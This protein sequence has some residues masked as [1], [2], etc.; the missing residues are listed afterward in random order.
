MTLDL[1][2]KKILV[3]DDFPEMRSMMRK[4]AVAF[5]AQEIDDARNGEDA[6]KLM[7]RNKYDIVLCDYNLGPGKDGQNVLEEAKHKSLINHSTVFMLITAENTLR[8]VMG[9]MEYV[10]DGYLTKPFTKGEFST[11][12]EKIQQKK[13]NLKEIEKAMQRNDY[14]A[15]VLACDEKLAENPPNIMELLKIKADMYEKMGDYEAAATV[16]NKV[17]DSREIAWASLGVARIHL[18]QKNYDDAKETLQRLIYEN[19]QYIEAYDLLAK[20]YEASDD[21]EE[22]QNILKKALEISPKAILRLKTLGQIA[23]KNSDLEVAESS[24]KNAVRLGKHSC[25]K[26]ASDYTGLAKV[27]LDKKSPVEALKLVGEIREMFEDNNHAAFQAAVMESMVHKQTGNS[28]LANQAITKANELFAAI[29]ENLPLDTVMDLAKTCLALG[30]AEAGAKYAK[31]IV[32]NHHEDEAV[33]KQTQALFNEF[34]MGDTGN[35]LINA[36][37]QEVIDVNNQGVRLAK[38]GKFEESIEFFEKAAGGMPE[39]KTVNLNAAQSLILFMQKSGKKERLLRQTMK[40]LERAKKIDPF[41]EK[42][43]K[44]MTFYTKLSTGK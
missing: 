9:A 8:M 36:A 1:T 20:V 28:E 17:L 4:M 13:A 21:L 3:V 26:E 7:E 39:N 6:L 31:Y 22:A 14:A 19:A 24:F 33:I 15:A 27:Y 10:P 23:Y 16:Y 32:Q 12:L 35:D 44:L 18:H 40:Y 30:N 34:N 5:R 2:G 37:R 42:Y 38:E 43:L 29:P 11:R 25:F 41:D